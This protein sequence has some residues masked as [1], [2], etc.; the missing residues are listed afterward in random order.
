MWRSLMEMAVG[1]WF[2]TLSILECRR[3]T[4]K[5]KRGTLDGNRFQLIIRHFVGLPL[6]PRLP[7]ASVIAI[8]ITLGITIGVTI[9]ITIALLLGFTRILSHHT[10]FLE[11]CII[12]ICV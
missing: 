1:K 8:P 7:S 10:S 9:G 12:F 2:R 6:Y 3:H 11:L 4:R 5:L